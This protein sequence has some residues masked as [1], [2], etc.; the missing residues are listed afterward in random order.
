L[1]AGTRKGIGFET[2]HLFT[3][4]VTHTLRS[5]SE[6]DIGDFKPFAY[7]A[8][9]AAINVFTLFLVTSRKNKAIK[10]NALNPRWMKT[11]FGDDEASLNTVDGAQTVFLLQ[12]WMTMGTKAVSSYGKDRTLLQERKADRVAMSKFGKGRRI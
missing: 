1:V 4:L 12:P 5:D 11:G 3:R 7:D 6:A 2:G 10:L 8:S 9:K